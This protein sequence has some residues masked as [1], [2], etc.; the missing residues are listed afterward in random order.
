MANSKKIKKQ[1]A[2]ISNLKAVLVQL[3]EMKSKYAQA[4]EEKNEL[5]S[6]WEGIFNTTVDG[7]IVTDETGTI[8]K[9]NQAAENMLGYSHDELTGMNT[10]ELR[11][12]GEEYEQKGLEFIARLLEEGII[13]G[14]ERAFVRKD[15][16]LI[17]V[18]VNT[19]FLKDS[20]GNF[21]GAVGS[22]R[23]ISERKLAEKRLNEYQHQLRSLASQLTLAEQQERRT[24]ATYL[25]DHI[26]QTLF[27]LKIKIEILSKALDAPH[28]SGTLQEINS[29]IEDLIRDT[30]SLTF[31]LSP[32]ILYQ[33]GLGAALEWLF[34]QMH[35]Q[36]SLEIAFEDDK[37]LK[38]L[39]DDI[40]V[41]L[42]RGV[43]ELLINVAKHAQAKKV[44]VSTRRNDNN[45]YVCV[46]DDGIGMQIPNINLNIHEGGGFG[47][48]SI[49]ERL[50]HL[51]GQLTI[52][53]QPACG[54]EVTLI[55]PLKEKG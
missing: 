52:H 3:E 23:D 49:K 5:K 8:T 28:L 25:H 32:P 40:L 30:R 14:W 38:Q 45:L 17:D 48:F 24:F 36:Y 50:E 13:K 12:A 39:D 33:L 29:I 4:E 20:K 53:S 31:E 41:L 51:G 27:V 16:S 35:Q 1:I 47:L 42:F 6:F 55:A 44:N 15:G 46:K 18:E 11:P 19:A 21:T 34:E 2:D 37:S 10:I 9:V 26:G 22:L 7:I 54:S 43:R